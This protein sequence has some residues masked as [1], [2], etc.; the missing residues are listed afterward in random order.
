M[1]NLLLMSLC[2]LLIISC[3][4]PT[5]KAEPVAEPE[6]SVV[7]DIDLIDNTKYEELARAGFQ[8]MTDQDLDAFLAN[9]ADDAVYVFNAGDSLA[10]MTAIREF[11]AGRMEVIETITFGNEIFLPVTVQEGAGPLPGDWLLAWFSVD[12]TYTSG[13]PCSSSY[14]LIIISTIQERLTELFSI[15]TGLRS[16]QH[17]RENSELT[18]P[19]KSRWI[20]PA[21]FIL[22]EL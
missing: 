19:M 10:G 8:G 9:F 11:W 21:F 3:S 13:D 12:A 5:E 7:R 14:T 6:P 17:R 15:W 22:L 16:W 20:I 18:T 2:V 1:K 4:A